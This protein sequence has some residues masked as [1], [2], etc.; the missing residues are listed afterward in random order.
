MRKQKERE[1]GGYKESSAPGV[2]G[3]KVYRYQIICHDLWW[4]SL[5][6]IHFHMALWLKRFS[7]ALEQRVV[8]ATVKYIVYSF[9]R[10]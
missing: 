8:T 10:S 6:G 9:M 1:S 5:L 3:L 2:V 7:A 4:G